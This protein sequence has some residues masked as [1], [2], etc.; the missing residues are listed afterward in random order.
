[1]GDVDERLALFAEYY[2]FDKV[3]LST[4]DYNRI[5]TLDG[6]FDGRVD[7][8]RV[9]EF[10]R[11][12]NIFQQLLHA[13]LL[14][15]HL[16]CRTVEFFPFEGVQTEGEWQ[17]AGLNFIC[18]RTPRTVGPTLVGHFFFSHPFESALTGF[19]MQY[20]MDVIDGAL[21]PLF[22]D[23]RVEPQDSQVIVLNFRGGDVFLG[24][25]ISAEY[26]QPPASF[27][28]LAALTARERFGVT[29]VS[30]VSEDRV[31]P[32]LAA[33][34]AALHEHGFRVVTNIPDLAGDIAIIMGAKH[35]VSP[36]GTFLEAL[37]MLSTGLRSYTA[38]R[39]FESHR[40]LH[41]ARPSLLV[42][43]LKA[44]GVIPIRILDTEQDYIRPLSWAATD[45]QLRLMLDFPLDRLT[46]QDLSAEPDVTDDCFLLW[47][48]PK[49]A[50]AAEAYRLRQALLSLRATV[51]GL[52]ED[53]S[54]MTNEATLQRLEAAAQRCRAGHLQQALTDLQATVSSLRDHACLAANDA[55]LRRTDAATAQIRVAHLRSELDA[56]HASSS[57][58]VTAPLRR[59][60]MI[61][62]RWSV[63]L[64]R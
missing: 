35:L 45:E 20:A 19:N 46:V 27:Y 61:V 52:R 44:R 21:R 6:H 12:G 30:I 29:T 10:G 59:A 33:T 28:I 51:V 7:A 56:M 18:R 42:H 5:D 62:R 57:W 37:A 25:P 50:S 48:F 3:S 36:F 24:N 13:I 8:I 23:V 26:V 11:F 15:H 4:K 40:H 16:G 1:M 49:A 54:K 34:E 14:A 47:P 31:N 22:K 39:Q 41:T 53:V 58:R 64:S 43:V 2:G 55:S 60:S 9:T 32:A 63:R 17:F 38:F